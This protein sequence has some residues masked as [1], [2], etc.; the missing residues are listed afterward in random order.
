[1]RFPI[2]HPFLFLTIILQTSGYVFQHTSSIKNGIHT[3]KT[4][5]GTEESTSFANVTQQVIEQL[6]DSKTNQNSGKF[7]KYEIPSGY[8]REP[9]FFGDETQQ[10]IS[11]ISLHWLNKTA[12][13]IIWPD[14]EENVILMT[15]SKQFSDSEKACLFE[16]SPENENSTSFSAAIIGCMDSEETIVN[17]S[18][19][20]EVQELL[21]LKN[22]T[23]IQNTW[24]KSQFNENLHPSRQK[25]SL[26]GRYK[27]QIY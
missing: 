24:N 8:S 11:E 22:G 13:K 10:T 25:R 26:S 19:N 4:N 16:G 3:P 12:I 18:V 20:N 7:K 14:Q 9:T 27:N 17:L 23:T 15:V 2:K 6:K 5:G 21:L 1:M